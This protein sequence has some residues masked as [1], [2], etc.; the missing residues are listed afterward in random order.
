ML[1]YCKTA[2][3]DSS[4]EHAAAMGIIVARSE[5]KIMLHVQHG[6]KSNV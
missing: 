6:T 5:M 4:Q 2:G 1:D 3:R